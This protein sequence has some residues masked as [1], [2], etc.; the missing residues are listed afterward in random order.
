M[1]LAPVEYDSPTGRERLEE[2]PYC[3]EEFANNPG[4]EIVAHLPCAETPSTDEAV[5]AARGER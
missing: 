1:S 4:G 5:E 3:G 2:C